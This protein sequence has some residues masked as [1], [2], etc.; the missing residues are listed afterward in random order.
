MDN[1]YLVTKH[2]KKRIHQRLG[3]GKKASD[4]LAKEAFEK[5]LTRDDLTGLLRKYIDE[6]Y[7][8]YGTA[9]NLRVYNQ[10]IFIFCDNR[11]VTVLPLNQNYYSLEQI[12]KEKKQKREA[13]REYCA[14]A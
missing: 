7:L 1:K 9:N 2:A 3:I 8:S 6:I 14:Y 4:R 5:G 12:M 11:L 10:K 13:E